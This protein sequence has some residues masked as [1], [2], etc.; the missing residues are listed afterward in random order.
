MT[1]DLDL[2][3][4]LLHLSVFKPSWD[5]NKFFI[6]FFK[7]NKQL[8]YYEITAKVHVP[9]KYEQ[10]CIYGVASK[11]NGTSKS[12]FTLHLKRKINVFRLSH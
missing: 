7:V 4:V 10:L 3:Q 1:F 2:I 8:L 9:V 6:F 5:L 12:E 11:N